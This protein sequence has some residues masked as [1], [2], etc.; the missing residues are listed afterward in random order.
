MLIMLRDVLVGPI[1]LKIGFEEASVGGSAIDNDER[2]G[3]EEVLEGQNVGGHGHAI[4]MSGVHVAQ[5]ALNAEE[6]GSIE[7]D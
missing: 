1:A 6:V 4:G 3:Q 5:L 2:A 7:V